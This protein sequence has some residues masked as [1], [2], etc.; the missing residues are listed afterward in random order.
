MKMDVSYGACEDSMKALC[1]ALWVNLVMLSSENE[2]KEKCML[3]SDHNESLLRWQP[4][5]EA[6][7]TLPF[8]HAFTHSIACWHICTTQLVDSRCTATSSFSSNQTQI[9]SMLHCGYREA[10][11]ISF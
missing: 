5:A 11:Y 7:T 1:K 6:F 4:G 10:Q 9:L 8:T 3:S 2:T